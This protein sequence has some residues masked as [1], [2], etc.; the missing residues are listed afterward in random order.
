MKI[1]PTDLSN[2]KQYRALVESLI[3][4]IEGG[5]VA[6]ARTA[7]SVAQQRRR[8]GSEC[9]MNQRLM[10]RLSGPYLSAYGLGA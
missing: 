5:R 2:V 3:R 9:D 8:Q 1:V 6:T 7:W 4:V 10:E